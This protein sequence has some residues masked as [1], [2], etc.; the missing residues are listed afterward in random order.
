LA[1]AHAV[2]DLVIE[3][4]AYRCFDGQMIGSDFPF[5]REFF[6]RGEGLEPRHLLIGHEDDRWFVFSPP[7]VRRLFVIDDQP[8]RPGQRRYLDRTRHH[9]AF[10][11]LRFGLRLHPAEE[12][13]LGRIARLFGK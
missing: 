11:D 5:A 2:L 9:G 13:I 10:G 4:H 3:G 7:N 12:G 1:P 6:S 8:V